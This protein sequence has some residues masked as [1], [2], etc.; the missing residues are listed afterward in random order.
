MHTSAGTDTTQQTYSLSL[1][2]TRAR[3]LSLARARERF[4]SLSLSQVFAMHKAVGAILHNK[5]L[6]LSLF[7]SLSLSLSHTR[8]CA[9]QTARGSDTAQQIYSLCL[10]LSL[11]LSHTH[12]HNGVSD[13]NSKREPYCTTNTLSHTHTQPVHAY[14]TGHTDCKRRRHATTTPKS[15]T[16]NPQTYY[17]LSPSPC[18]S[19]SL[20]LSLSL[21]LSLARSL[22]LSD[23]ER[24]RHDTTTL[25]LNTEK[26]RCQNWFFLKFFLKKKIHREAALS[27]LHRLLVLLVQKYKY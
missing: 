24:R 19:L 14:T 1:S 12:A 6:S 23:C 7:L 13:T 26:P 2:L 10:S 20:F 16:E 3:S 8:A 17:I 18:P 21:S 22:S 11:S 15:N 9:T 25:Q 4:L 5:H 27:K